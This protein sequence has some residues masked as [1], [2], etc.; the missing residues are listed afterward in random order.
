MARR[1][2]HKKRSHKRGHIP[3]EVLKRRL[4]K[5]ARVVHKRTR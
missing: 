4:H 2:H 1:R 3:L 5:L